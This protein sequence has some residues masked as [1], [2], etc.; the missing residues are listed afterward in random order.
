MSTQWSLLN[1][2]N[3]NNGSRYS[4]FRCPEPGVVVTGGPWFPSEN[5]CPC[6]PK[7]SFPSG[8]GLTSCPFGVME[9]EKRPVAQLYNKIPTQQEITGI[10]YNDAQF[11]P[12]QMDP[13]PLTRI[14]ESWRS[15]N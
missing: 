5:V 12:P 3:V 7:L 11:I 8:R 6:D 4:I 13:R 10:I 2:A 1:Q 15:A 14:G 9:P